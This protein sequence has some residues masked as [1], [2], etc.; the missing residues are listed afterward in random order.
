MVAWTHLSVV[1]GQWDEEEG[2]AKERKKMK[3]SEEW[4]SVCLC[5]WENDREK[6]SGSGCTGEKSNLAFVLSYSPL[7]EA[8]YA[9]ERN[10]ILI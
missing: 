5:V 7:V 1:M 9:H 2:R 4:M 10:A 8:L 6:E 3:R